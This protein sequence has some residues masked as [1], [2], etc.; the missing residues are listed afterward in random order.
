MIE[1]QTFVS[2]L[3]TQLT[4]SP[5]PSPLFPLLFPLQMQPLRCSSVAIP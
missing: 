3:A 5:S 4:S 1:I 2:F